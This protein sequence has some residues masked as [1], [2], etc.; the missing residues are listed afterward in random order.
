MVW[1]HLCRGA[2]L[3]FFSKKDQAPRKKRKELYKNVLKADLIFWTD[4]DITINLEPFP[5][6][7]TNV[8]TM[9]FS[10]T[11]FLWP[12]TLAMASPKV[13]SESGSIPY[14]MVDKDGK[15]MAKVSFS[16]R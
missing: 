3:I 7:M 2:R 8:L 1:S 4:V 15:A 16:H 13:E 9:D 6:K 11:A 10:A 14:H 5:N 12:R